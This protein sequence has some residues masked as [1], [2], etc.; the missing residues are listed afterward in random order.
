[1]QRGTFVL[2]ILCDSA[3]PIS[4]PSVTF[5]TPVFHPNI[6]S[7]TGTAAWTYVLSYQK[8]S[9]GEVCMD[10]LKEAWSPIWT[11]SCLCRAIISL[12]EDPNPHSP[13]C[14]DAGTII[15][16]LFSFNNFQEKSVINVYGLA[17]NLI[18]TGDLRGFQ[19]LARM[20][21]IDYATEV[22]PCFNEKK[23]T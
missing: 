8:C 4:P 22:F 19:S 18:R 5:K 16:N 9:I 21:T 11:L 15:S 7:Q 14:C 10:V 2:K 6:N 1:V 17:G 3:F 23:T 12:L 20:Y 13:L